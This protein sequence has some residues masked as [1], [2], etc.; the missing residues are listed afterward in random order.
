MCHKLRHIQSL[1]WMDSKT[2][3]AFVLP[4]TNME[5]IWEEELSSFSLQFICFH[6]VD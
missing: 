4:K 1:A 6:W 5:G 2:F 3:R